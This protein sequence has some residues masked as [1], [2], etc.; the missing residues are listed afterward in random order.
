DFAYT[1]KDRTGKMIEGTIQAQNSAIAVGRVREMG[2]EVEKVRPLDP[3]MTLVARHC[4]TAQ[5]MKENFIYP[6]VSGVL[7]KDLALFYRQFA[8]MINAGIPLYQSL[9]S[10]EGQTRNPKL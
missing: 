10:L 9:A 3:R 5:R 2:Y 1:A 7:L 4:G 6:V 8:T